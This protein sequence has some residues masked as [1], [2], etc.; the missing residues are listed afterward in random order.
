MGFIPRDL[1]VRP[2]LTE[3]VYKGAL[4]KLSPTQTRQLVLDVSD[5]KG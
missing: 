5:S 4:Q 3:T 1:V 2:R